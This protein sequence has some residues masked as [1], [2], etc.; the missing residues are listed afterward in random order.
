VDTVDLHH[1]DLPDPVI[2][3]FRCMQRR[4]DRLEKKLVAGGGSI[5]PDEAD[6]TVTEEDDG[7]MTLEA[8]GWS[9]HL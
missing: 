4:M 3:M 8:A 1:E 6:L 5:E 9:C 7:S 2:E